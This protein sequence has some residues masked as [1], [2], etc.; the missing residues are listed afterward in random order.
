M[1]IL[2]MT[3]KI[4]LQRDSIT[5]NEFQYF[6]K[7]G[8][9]LDLNTVELKPCKWISDIT[10]LNLVALS[11]LRQF[12][13]I[14]SQV[15]ASE[16]QWKQWF[17]KEAPEEEV[18]PNEYNNLDTFRRLLLI[19]A[20]CIDRTLSQSRKYIASALGE[21]FAEPVIT[22]LDVM[23]SES[24]PNTPMICF[25]S[26]GSD[27]TPSIELLAKRMETMCKTISMGQGQEVH[28][29]K[30]LQSAKTEVYLYSRNMC[31]STWKILSIS[32][33]FSGLLGTVSKLSLG[34][35]LYVRASQFSCG[36]GYTT[37]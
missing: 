37:S 1:F 7:G 19:R 22:L 18:I 29:R 25:L 27:P 14:L 36:N 13:Y 12:Q 4:D 21:R 34:F 24:R 28:A 9:A 26:M 8:A 32:H 20:W 11:V 33:T 17:D 6:I 10:W 2:L 23:H 31:K 16:K 30:L 35:R 5:Y 3:L 15:P